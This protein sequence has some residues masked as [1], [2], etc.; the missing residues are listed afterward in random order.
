MKPGMDQTQG[1]V[2]ELAG[3]LDELAPGD[4][5]R[6]TW[7]SSR[8]TGSISVEGAV[9]HHPKAAVKVTTD[10]RKSD[11]VVKRRGPYELSVV[12]ESGPR[13][14]TLGWLVDVERYTTEIDRSNQG[15]Q[16]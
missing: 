13:A 14:E 12:A 6:L 15:D 5:V 3:S 9:R 2:D 1:D 10:E 16:R 11:I 4:K 7:G 8:S